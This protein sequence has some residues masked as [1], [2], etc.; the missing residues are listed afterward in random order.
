ME[1]QLEF[2]GLIK[3]SETW[4]PT[5]SRTQEALHISSSQ[6]SVPRNKRPRPGDGVFVA[7]LPVEAAQN[8]VLRSLNVTRAAEDDPEDPEAAGPPVIPQQSRQVGRPVPDDHELVR[9][10]EGHP[11]VQASVFLEGSQSNY[12]SAGIVSTRVQSASFSSKSCEGD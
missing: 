8:A 5:M 7:D 4:I 3:H 11:A 9:I 12:C 10:Y 1:C 6:I 2:K